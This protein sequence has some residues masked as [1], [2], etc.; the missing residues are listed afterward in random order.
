MWELEHTERMGIRPENVTQRPWA[1]RMSLSEGI[2]RHAIRKCMQTGGVRGHNSLARQQPSEMDC[3][4]H[5]DWLDAQSNCTGVMNLMARV[6]P[7]RVRDVTLRFQREREL[8]DI[9]SM[10]FLWL[11]T[12]DHLRED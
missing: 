12:R 3:R 6:L 1:A 11:T 9:W 8:L 7:R 10:V 4:N 5:A 2:T